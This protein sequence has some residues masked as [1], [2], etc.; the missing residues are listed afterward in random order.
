MPNKV[1]LLFESSFNFT[2]LVCAAVAIAL[3]RLNQ[4]LV[5]NG[6][7]IRQPSKQGGRPDQPAN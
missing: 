1:T 6:L 5:L 3:D 7:N 4:L 2:G